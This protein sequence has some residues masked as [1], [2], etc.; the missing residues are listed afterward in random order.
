MAG[1]LHQLRCSPLL[2]VLH[3]LLSE[4]RG[5]GRET[6]LLGVVCLTAC[7]ESG[8]LG[9]ESSDIAQGAP[10]STQRISSD[11]QP[12]NIPELGWCP[13]PSTVSSRA[14]KRSV[15]CVMQRNKYMMSHQGLWEGPALARHGCSFPHLM[16]LSIEER[17][18]EGQV[19]LSRHLLV[20]KTHCPAMW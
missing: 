19:L 16:G 13:T 5:P 11:I 9:Q 17:E 7:L 10:A 15:F 6:S 14:A 2:N 18:N 1:G 8:V 20:A 12:T 4:P 3:S